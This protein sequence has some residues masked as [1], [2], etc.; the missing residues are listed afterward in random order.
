MQ[1]FGDESQQILGNQA[2][3]AEPAGTFSVDPGSG[4]RSRKRRHALSQKTTGDPGKDIS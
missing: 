4:G 3:A 1:R 2:R